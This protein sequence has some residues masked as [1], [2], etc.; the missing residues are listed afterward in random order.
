MGLLK[1]VFTWWE[2]ATI[3]TSLGLR[4]KTKIGEDSL[5]NIY[6]LSLIHI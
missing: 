3:G 6:Y 5:G 4:G 1:S 2:G